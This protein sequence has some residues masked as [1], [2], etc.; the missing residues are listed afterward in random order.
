MLPP[1]DQT[2]PPALMGGPWALLF[3]HSTETDAGEALVCSAWSPLSHG[4]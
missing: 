2:S 3:V 1:I 4:T